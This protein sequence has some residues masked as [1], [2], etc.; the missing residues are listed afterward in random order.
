MRPVQNAAFASCAAQLDLEMG[1][2]RFSIFMVWLS[3]FP[4]SFY[5]WFS[6]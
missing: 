1:A 2:A 3:I 6:G 4:G 5:T